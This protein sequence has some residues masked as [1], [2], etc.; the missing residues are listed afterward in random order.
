MP[1]TGF[2]ARHVKHLSSAE[3]AD[4]LS[5]N[6]YYPV[7]YARTLIPEVPGHSSPSSTISGP[8]TSTYARYVA[9]TS[10]TSSQDLHSHGLVGFDSSFSAGQ[11]KRKLE[12]PSS[13]SDADRPSKRHT[14]GAYVYPDTGATYSFM[15]HPSDIA[16]ETVYT[17]I[18]VSAPMSR[19]CAWACST[20]PTTTAGDAAPNKMGSLSQSFAPSGSP[21]YPTNLEYRN[22]ARN[23]SPRPAIAPGQCIHC[24][25]FLKEQREEL[26]DILL[27]TATRAFPKRKRGVPLFY[28]STPESRHRRTRISYD[29]AVIGYA[30]RQTQA[31]GARRHF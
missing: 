18:P 2:W 9:D 10:A 31:H 16:R 29:I 24:A 5:F 17:S 21:F 22:L 26:S 19:E 7:S 3:P 30:A 25:T 27:D 11:R 8:P 14:A 12:D 13:S 20:Y 28:P 6:S 4:H 1:G 23:S 15:G